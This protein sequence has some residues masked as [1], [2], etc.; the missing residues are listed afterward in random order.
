MPAL[1]SCPCVPSSRARV[2]ELT[3]D[4]SRWQSRRFEANL[5]FAQRSK[6]MAS[7]TGEAVLLTIT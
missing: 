2:N 4:A 7:G 3:D 5:L 1:G 6:V